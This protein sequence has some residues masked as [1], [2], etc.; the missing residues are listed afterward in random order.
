MAG[1]AHSPLDHVMDSHHWDIF[2]SLHFSIPLG[3]LSKFM[4]LELIAAGLILWIYI[5]LARRIESGELPKGRWWNLFEGVLTFVRNEI[6]RPNLHDNTDKCLPFLWT[7]FLFILFNN[8]LGLL[9]F[10]GSPT[11]S[12]WV[13]GALALITFVIMHLMGVLEVGY[14]H[15]KHHC[16][17]HHT[18]PNKV[19]AIP[20][21]L[22]YYL[23][24][25]WPK[26]GDTLLAN[27]LLSPISFM[28]WVIELLGTVIKCGVLA[29]RLFANMFAGHMVLATILLFVVNTGYQTI[30]GQQVAMFSG[31]W[32]VAT[33][34]S[35]LG[36]FALS[37]LELFVAFLQAYVFTFLTALFMGMQMHPE[38]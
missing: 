34:S 17:E 15:Y 18:E 25:L 32:V 1:A 37:L 36:S 23:S 7:L 6:A 5:P 4:L 35:V 19:L 3:P 2:E 33:T 21:S 38:H 31:G 11:A 13:T 28:L 30:N 16:H 8:L 24:A 29:V 12:I 22:W 14:G 9:P 26:L 10:M 20:L 27:L